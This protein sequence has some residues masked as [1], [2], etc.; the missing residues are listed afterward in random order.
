MELKTVEPFAL[1][2]TTMS[3]FWVDLSSNNMTKLDISNVVTENRF[4]RYDF[5][6]NKII[7]IV[8]EQNF[9]INVHKKYHGGFVDLDSNDSTQ[10]FDLKDLGIHDIFI[11]GKIRRFG[12]SLQKLKWT[13]DCRMEPFYELSQDALPRIW[14]DFL[15]VT[16]WDPPEYRG[17][18]ITEHFVKGDRLDLLICNKTSA[19]KCPQKCYCFYQ[20]KNRKTVVNCTDVGLT[21]LPKFVPEGDNLTLLFDGNNIEFLEHREYFNRSSVISLSNNRLHTI[22]SN[23]IEIIG[24]NAVLDLSGNNMNKLPRYIQTFDPCITKLGKIKISC[25]CDDHWLVDWVKNKRA[26]KCRNTTEIICFIG[27]EYVS[28]IDLD[29]GKFYNDDDS[30]LKFLTFYLD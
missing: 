4:C 30:N 11:L 6:S 22:S 23:A 27:D 1:A 29:L 15:N 16:C 8:N 10:W 20:P 14:R 21:A 28:T 24:S 7:Q 3:I 25:S 12:F 18:S 9:Q 17:L 13:C 2:G 19:D 26:E 5:S